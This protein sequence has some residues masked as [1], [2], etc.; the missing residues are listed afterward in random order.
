MVGEGGGRKNINVRIRDTTSLSTNQRKNE[1]S[2]KKSKTLVADGWDSLFFSHF[3]H[4]AESSQFCAVIP[5]RN[6]IFL[7]GPSGQRILNPP[8]KKDDDDDD[9]QQMDET[10]IHKKKWRKN[11][12]KEGMNFLKT[13]RRPIEKGGSARDPSLRA[14]TSGRFLLAR[15]GRCLYF[16]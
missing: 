12:T 4:H 15:M 1:C 9:K 5:F 2:I 8:F 13:D 16:D 6:H 14:S 11:Y 10:K 3:R 7:R